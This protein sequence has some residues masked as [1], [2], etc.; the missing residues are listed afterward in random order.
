[1]EKEA[2]IYDSIG[3]MR[4][5]L[6]QRRIS[7]EGA[8]DKEHLFELINNSG[9]LPTLLNTEIKVLCQNMWIHHI[10]GGP[11]P[12]ARVRGLI[13]YLKTNQF[14]ILMLQEVF[15]LNSL[16]TNIG[17][18]YKSTLIEECS[19]L[20]Y[21]YNAQAHKPW[22][23]RQDSGLLILSKL[24]I[25]KSIANVFNARSWTEFICEKGFLV[26]EIQISPSEVL[27]CVD[28]H[29]D[30]HSQDVRMSEFKQLQDYINENYKGKKIILAG[31]F[32]MPISTTTIAPLSLRRSCKGNG[33]EID[34][35]FSNLYAIS[36]SIIRITKD[37]G[38][39]RISDH[40]AVLSSF[41]L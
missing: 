31:D 15:I 3:Y 35:I 37:N 21:Y 14:D 38:S 9:G 2:S 4:A 1:M 27:I 16:F 20:G 11:E 8:V 19:K 23:P 18:Q 24:P 36:S 17:E 28:V 32:N 41:S 12:D 30:A 10:V 40:D 22:L 13:E 34:H 33:N 6:D 29:F 39:S 25:L 5:V 7:Y 26:A